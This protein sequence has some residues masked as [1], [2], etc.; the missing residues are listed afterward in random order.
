[1]RLA[2]DGFRHE[3]RLFMMPDPALIDRANEVLDRL[4]A[5]DDAIVNARAF[6]ALLENL[7][8]RDLS[9]VT[10]QHVAAISMVRAGILRAAIG[11][12]MACLDPKDSRGNR[13]SVGQILDMLQDEAV[14]AVFPEAEQAPDLGAAALQ[15]ARREYHALLHGDLFEQGRRLRNDAIAHI[16]IP[17]DPTPTVTYE[18]I[19]ALGD[20][21]ARLVRNLYQVCYRGRPHFIEE[22]AELTEHANTFWDTYFRGMRNSTSA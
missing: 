9:V 4:F 17:H 19:H 16:L 20:A 7:H 22:D 13:A 18:T 14:V 3:Q 5:L 11:S 10:G 2:S 6:R 21:A 15:E 1:M 8:A 12:V